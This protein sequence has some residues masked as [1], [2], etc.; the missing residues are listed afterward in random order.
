MSNQ[1]KISHYLVLFLYLCEEGERVSIIILKTWTMNH[2][3]YKAVVFYPDESFGMTKLR[4]VSCKGSTS[5]GPAL[6]K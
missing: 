4:K 2:I 5:Y 1:G 3:N 6:V